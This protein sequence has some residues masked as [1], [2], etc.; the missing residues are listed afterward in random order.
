MTIDGYQKQLHQFLLSNTRLIF[1][2]NEI[3]ID[4]SAEKTKYLAL[5][6]ALL[7]EIEEV[8]TSTDY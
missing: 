8:T 4:L 6:V 5:F 1:L 2:K 7:P 3:S